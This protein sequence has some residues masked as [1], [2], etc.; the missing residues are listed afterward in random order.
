MLHTEGLVDSQ[1]HSF[2]SYNFQIQPRNEVHGAFSAGRLKICEI[3]YIRLFWDR[4]KITPKTHIWRFEIL[5][6]SKSY[7][8]P[9]HHLMIWIWNL[10]FMGSKSVVFNAIFLPKLL[11]SQA[12]S[13]FISLWVKIHNTFAKIISFCNLRH[14]FGQHVGAN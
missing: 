14:D 1:S 3:C 2:V 10:E 13:Y 9:T 11:R 6:I 8:S 5:E 4:I 12:L 7:K